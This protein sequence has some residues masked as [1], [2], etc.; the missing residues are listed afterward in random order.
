MTTHG[1]S[2]PPSPEYQAWRNMK[3]RCFNKNNPDYK[4]YG[5]RGITID[6]S[7]VNS[8]ETFLTDMGLRP[9][10]YTL[11]RLD[12]NKDYSK[13]NCVW[14]PHRLQPRNR[15]S[16]KLDLATANLIRQMYAKGYWR[17]VDLAE[18]FDIPQDWVSKIVRNQRWK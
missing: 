2:N 9:K 10:G 6:P 7:W 16:N 4:H 3:Q 17:Q 11:E 5:G 1:Y 15:G 8:F 18:Q 13:S 12:N 14:L